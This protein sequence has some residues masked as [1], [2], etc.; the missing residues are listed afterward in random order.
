MQRYLGID[1]HS[2]SSTVCVLSAAGK[3]VRQDV[4]ETN[5]Q[6]LVRYLR[7]L[8]DRIDTLGR[9]L[10]PSATGTQIPLE[11]LAEIRYTPGPQVIKSEDTFLVGYVV[12]DKRPGTAE[13]DVVEDER[14]GLID[15]CDARARRRIGL[16]PGMNGKCIETGFALLGHR[17]LPRT[18]V[19]NEMGEG[20]YGMTSC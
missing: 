6:A 19:G 5:G 14:C 20:Q 12:F 3:K 15:R 1:V 13:V 17:Y 18:F 8:R 2:K 9:I 7:E 11:Q 16:C 4:V 10:V